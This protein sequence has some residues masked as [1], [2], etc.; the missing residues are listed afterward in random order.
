MSLAASADSP[1]TVVGAGPVGLVTAWAPADAG[2]PVRVLEADTVDR[3]DWRASTF[4]AATLRAT[5][6]DPDAARVWLRR[7]SL[8]SAVAEQG[9]GRPLDA[10]AS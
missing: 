5:A 1:V 10:T 3:T 8:L 6:A 4:H 7:A 2:V 9:I